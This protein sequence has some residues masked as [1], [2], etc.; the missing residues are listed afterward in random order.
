M[1]CADETGIAFRIRA[2]FLGRTAEL[3]GLYDDRRAGDGRRMSLPHNERRASL[4]GR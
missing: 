2:N 4:M 3:L 1:S